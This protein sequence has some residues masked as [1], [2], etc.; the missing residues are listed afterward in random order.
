MISDINATENTSGLDRRGL[1]AR[2]SAGSVSAAAFAALAAGGLAITSTPALAQGITDADVFNFALNSE[3]LESEYYL[4]GVTGAGLS[5]AD[6]TGT[7]LRG[8]VNG[9]RAVPFRSDYLRQ[10]FT[11]IAVD[12]LA[13]VRFLRAVLGNVAISRPTIDFTAAFTDIAVAA[14]LIQPGQTFD[15]F[16]DEVSF[17]LGSYSLA[18]VGVTAYAGAAPLLTQPANKSYGASILAVEAYHA[19]A[20]RTLL[21]NIGGGAASNAISALRARLSGRPDD[22]G[23]LVPGNNFNFVPTDDQSQVF[24]RTPRQILNIIYGAPNATSGG[25][26]P[27][28][29][30]GSIRS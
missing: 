17:V 23:I 28:G 27:N 11:R 26:F 15:P 3:Y 10:Y 12:E 5:D 14:G 21:G 4:R 6:T 18:D 2:V 1:L 16:A 9:G 13:H 30:N 7:G 25:F 22:V 24:R 8:A 29:V 20:A 19:G